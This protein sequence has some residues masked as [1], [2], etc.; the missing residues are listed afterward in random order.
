MKWLF[1]PIPLERQIE[2]ETEARRAAD[3]PKSGEIASMMV[4]HAYKLQHLL[5]LAIMEIARLDADQID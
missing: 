1:E 2:I 5:N 4:R 3:H